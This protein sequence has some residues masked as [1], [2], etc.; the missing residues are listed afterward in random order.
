MASAYQKRGT[1]YVGFTDGSGK[2]R[3][4]ATA[5]RT[6]T[7][8]RRI[9]AELERKAERQRLGLDPLPDDSVTLGG[10][11]EAWLAGMRARPAFET[12][13]AYIRLHVRETDLARTPL[14][15]L[16]R[17]HVEN[18]LDAEAA[19]FKP[20]TVN[21][22]RG[23][24]CAA[25]NRAC[26]TGEWSGSNVVAEVPKRK[27]PRR[28]PAYLRSEEVAPLLAALAPRF[29]NVFATAIFTGLR[30]S[31]L[32]A[33]RKQDVDLPRRWLVVSR[34]GSRNVT[35]GNR[36]DGLPIAEELVPFLEAALAGSPGE[37]V[38]PR[39]DGT[40]LPR[41]TP[42]SAI[43]RRAM[44]RAGVAVTG[45]RHACRRHGCGHAETTPDAGLRRCPVDGRKLWPT[46]EVRPL[47]FYDAT[48]HTTAS[49]LLQQGAP[50][51]A[52]QKIMRHSTPTLTTEVYG[53]LAGD[54]LRAEANRLR[55]GLGTPEGLP[56]RETERLV[57][58]G[59]AGGVD[60]GSSTVTSGR[61]ATRALPGS[62]L[63]GRG[64]PAG[65]PNALSAN[66]I[67]GA[68]EGDRTLDINLGK[69]ALYR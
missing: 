19:R 26:R 51:Q 38:F 57:S 54:Y 65:A 11:C 59:G 41:G 29:R 15:R 3:N 58:V 31:E 67:R 56:L 69:V 64:D 52:V 17:A 28:P 4:V 25:I 8:A 60:C 55:F 1:Y 14:G 16:T 12:S 68:G 62:E 44:G 36:V 39:P 24:L 50:L 47:R 53:H 34:S 63:G 48:R 20:E 2:R 23:I 6:L 61:D 43:L 18:F 13:E 49:L 21:R 7:E 22:L 30:P 27:V 42:F 33:L 37:L 10:A 32:R 40:M 66:G 45:F 5:A 9:A 46:P 35:K